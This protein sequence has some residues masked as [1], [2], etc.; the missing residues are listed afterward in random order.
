M[1]LTAW[2]IVK[3]KHEATAFDGEGARLYG[4]RWN[5]SGKRVVYT[6]ENVSLALLELLVHIDTSLLPTYTLIPVSFNDSVVS[7]LDPSLLPD[8]W[9]AHPGPFELRK[10]GDDW[11]E[12]LK[13][14]VLQVPSAVVPQEW[15]YLLSP[16]HPESSSIKIGIAI[17]FEIDLRMLARKHSRPFDGN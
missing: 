11:L 3:K 16:A 10:I 12:S 17:P 8:D 6:A 13:S 9:R 15:N 7:S 5:S 4:G 14:P 1:I 2:R